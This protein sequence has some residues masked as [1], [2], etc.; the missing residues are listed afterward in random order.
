TGGLEK[1]IHHIHDNDGRACGVEYEWLCWHTL[2]GKS[3]G[4][5][6]A[7][8][9][10]LRENVASC[11]GW[12]DTEDRAG[13]VSGLPCRAALGRFHQIQDT[14]Q[15][16]VHPVGTAIEFVT[17]LVEG[18]LQEV[19]IQEHL[20]FLPRL[21]EE[22]PLVCDSAVGIQEGG[23]DPE[24]PDARPGGEGSE[25]F[26]TY[27][28]GLLEQ[29]AIDRIVKRPEHTCDIAQRRL[30][31]AP[32]ADRARRLAL[33]VNNDKILPGVEHLPQMIVP[34]D[35]GA[36]RCDA[37]VTNGPEALADISFARKHSL[38]C[39]LDGWWQ[40]LQPPTEEPEGLTRLPQHTLVESLPVKVRQGFWGKAGVVR[41]LGECHVQFA[42]A[43][44]E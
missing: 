31:E 20:A 42:G 33:E 39:T 29:G 5:H 43:L 18:L 17:Q 14:L 7:S 11:D 6:R 37:P 23:T 16:D 12:W 27:I 8:W 2:F 34:V 41:G 38:G 4:C 40:G 26:R 35:A 10:V 28:S 32:H 44:A 24:I 13:Y 30:F 22:R 1:F 25:V 36:H 3:I 15:R 9:R 21:G 19:G